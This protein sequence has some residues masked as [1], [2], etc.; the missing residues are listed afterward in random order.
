MSRIHLWVGP[1][2]PFPWCWFYGATESEVANA[3]FVGF[4]CARD[5]QWTVPPQTPSSYRF[6]SSI[7]PQRSSPNIIKSLFSHFVRTAR[8]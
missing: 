5:W 4:W 1:L 2:L 8:R 3:R 7:F 6:H